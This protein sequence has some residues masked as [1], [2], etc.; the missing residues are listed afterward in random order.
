MQIRKFVITALLGSA[1]ALATATAAHAQTTQTR[2]VSFNVPAG[3]LVSGLRKFSRQARVE[4]IYKASD[5]R[6]RKTPGVSGSLTVAEALQRLLAGS[7]A[8]LVRD[9]S[10]AY[11]VR[12]V[13]NGGA[14]TSGSQTAS[15]GGEDGNEGSE[16]EE[17][18]VTGSNI[19]G[20][21]I[22]RPGLTLTRRD[23]EDSAITS[24]QQL[25]ESLPQNFGGGQ[26]GASEDGAIGPG[27]SAA[28]NASDAT[29]VNLR[30]L[31]AT[32]TLV[33][34]NGRRLAPSAFGNIADVSIIPIDA[35]ERVE[36][37]TD[38]S[39]AIYG[40]D[41]VA[42]V[43]NFILRSD[44]EGIE[45]RARVGLPTPGGAQEVVLSGSAGQKW[46]TG[47]VLAS[48]QYRWRNNL[49]SS[50]RHFTNEA[51]Q[52]TDL[53]PKTEEY[54][55]FLHANQEIGPDVEIFAELLHAQKN[56]E[57]VFT[58]VLRTQRTDSESK[59]TSVTGGLRIN[60]LSDWRVEAIASYSQN[61]GSDPT[62]YTPELAGFPNGA[63]ASPETYRIFSGDLRAD[64]TVAELPGGPL[65]IALGTFYREEKY[66]SD[67]TFTGSEI[68]F[69]RDVKG[70]FAELNVPIV[71]TGP[72]L[73]DRLTLNGAI[74]YEDYSDFGDATTYRL[75]L[76]YAPIRD[77]VF[78]AFYNTSFRAPT[79]SEISTA[80]AG[81]FILTDDTF[82]APSGSS[83]FLLVGS[84]EDL[85]PEKA[86]S[87]S[88]GAD[89]TPFGA[90]GPKLSVTYYDIRYRDR[91]TIPPYDL[92]AL[93][94]PE[95]Y[96]S[97][98]TGFQSDAQS[99]SFLDEEIAAGAMF[100]DLTGTGAS[101]VRYAYSIRQQNVAVTKQSGWDI[102]LTDS[103]PLFDGQMNLSGNVAYIKQI[104]TQFSSGATAIDISN[105]Y[106]NPLHFRGRLHGSWSGRNWTIFGAINHAGGYRDTSSSPERDASSWTTAD[107]GA[108]HSWGEK[109]AGSVTLRASNIFNDA[110]PFVRGAGANGI[111][112]DTANGDPLGRVVS[113]EFRVGF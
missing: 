26:A 113:L 44:Y 12:V 48:A 101:G 58:N 50:S 38:G 72:V 98:I 76:N 32:S 83:I 104:L 54:N 59:S 93:L 16:D 105:T 25:V 62:T 70:A 3:D 79:A 11:L 33:L 30:G 29:G 45:A 43:I 2:Q 34:L 73:L 46:S 85:R 1:A 86:K 107:L 68:R 108:R 102:G 111:H 77:L 88:L 64:G 78:R 112:Y 22:D 60:P 47:N 37:L 40:S 92:S 100:F 52:P 87:I 89:A 90:D 84:E 80:Q 4:V 49:R 13:R 66:K 94:R 61:K 36:V 8:T 82:A 14:G 99:Q 55:L 91:I 31:G 63:P 65:K 9:P 106:G 42:G 96:G 6:G 103:F 74:R 27:A 95:V 19:R 23:I 39:S 35:I 15:T 109:K 69:N 67:V 75:G 18:V 97:L 17:I 24:T 53:L 10:G 57:R 7:G 81:R 20:S 5:L 41:A 110:P 71:S 21:S 51:L 28:F 56:G